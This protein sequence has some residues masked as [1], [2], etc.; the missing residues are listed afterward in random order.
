MRERV[1]RLGHDLTQQTYD[2]ALLDDALLDAFHDLM[3]RLLADERAQW[4]LYRVTEGEVPADGS[5]VALPEGCL[6]LLKVQARLSDG[7]WCSLP[8]LPGA[9]WV[10][11]EDVA[12]RTATGVAL[13]ISGRVLGLTGATGMPAGWRPNEDGESVALLP[14]G[15][16]G[17]TIRMGYLAAQEWPVAARE[18]V[19]LPEGADE[20]LELLAADKLTADEPR[21]EQRMAMYMTRFEAR[22]GRWSAGRARG[23][24]PRGQQVAGETED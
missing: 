15:V 18:S 5:A 10:P 17:A 6:R 23:A 8:R 24:V 9:G 19:A 20:L 7:T 12:A 2:S 13:G 16:A 22:Y 1:R 14:T 3:D 11:A 21:D 4:V